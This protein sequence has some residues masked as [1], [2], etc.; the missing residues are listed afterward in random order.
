MPVS[1]LQ[2]CPITAPMTSDY[3]H[4]S[5]MQTAL[6][7]AGRGQGRTAPNPSVGCVIVKDGRVVGRGNTAPG[8]RPH[9]ET[10]ALQM[11]GADAKGA[12]AYVTLEPC[13]HY[14]K[15]PPCAEA[16]IK[17]GIKR[18]V[19]A[20]MDPNPQ[21]NGAGMAMLK[22]AGIEVTEGVCKAEALQIN[23]G[24]FKRIRGEGCEVTVKI[25]TTQD[26]SF[27][28]PKERW[29]TGEQS[30]QFVHLM[31][32]QHDAILTG[33]G[34]VLADDPELTC[35]LPGMEN[36]SPKPYVLD[37]HLRIPE[38]AKLIRP[39]TVIFTQEKALSQTDKISALNRKGAEVIALDAPQGRISLLAAVSAVA[40]GGM[41]RLMV[42]AGPE[43]THAFLAS[44]LSSALYWF[45]AP[46]I[47][48]GSGKK[49]NADEIKEWS[50][51]KTSELGNDQLQIWENKYVHP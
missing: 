12:T 4:E 33:I 11:A 21:V 23:K 16:L 38:S 43:L 29:I 9:A 2:K 13:S 34:T 20:C 45:M 24:F 30:R 48:S 26:G 28:H 46:H 32:A 42:E 22:N 47:P 41:N 35:R 50:I 7:L 37:S 17:A 36:R 40:A 3:P 31:R 27:T 25:A 8:G 1:F 39:G 51:L 14:G 18:A 10:I 15:T 6:L 5:F 49:L 19:I 44:G